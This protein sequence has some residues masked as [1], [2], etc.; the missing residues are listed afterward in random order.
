MGL[1][2]WKFPEK[3]LVVLAGTSTVI[4]GTIRH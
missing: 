2:D 4:A 3:D 1:A